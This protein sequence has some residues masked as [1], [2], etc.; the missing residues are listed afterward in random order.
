MRSESKAGF[1]RPRRVEVVSVQS[2]FLPSSAV[3]QFPTRTP[4]RLT[5]FTRRM[6]AARIRAKKAA[7]GS[8]IRQPAYRRQSQV[9]RRRGVRVLFEC[10]SVP[11][12]HGPVEG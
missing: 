11:C 10:D 9:N 7:I 6:P 2:N 5:P 3:S 8:F 12:D 1:R 4:S